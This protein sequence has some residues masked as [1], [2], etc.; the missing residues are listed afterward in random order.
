MLECDESG[1]RNRRSAPLP[2]EEEEE[3]DHVITSRQVYDLPLVHLNASA[4]CFHDLLSVFTDLPEQ[5]CGEEWVSDRN[6]GCWTGKDM[7]RWV[8]GVMGVSVWDGEGVVGGGVR[9]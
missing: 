5:L 3:G 6:G 4:F 7:G 1:P 8:E 2:S 9:V